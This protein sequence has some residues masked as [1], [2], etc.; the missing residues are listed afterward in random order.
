MSRLLDVLDRAPDHEDEA[1]EAEVLDAVR[2][3]TA[4]DPAA[5][6]EVHAAMTKHRTWALVGWARDAAAV[7]VRRRDREWVVLGLVGLSLFGR[8]FDPRDALLIYPLLGRAAEKLGEDRPA[9]FEEAA[10]LS[11][12]W[13]ERWLA[14]LSTS[15]ASP[16]TMGFEEDN[17]DGRF[18]FRSTRE[19]NFSEADLAD[20][21]NS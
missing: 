8:D 16:E 10:A 21:L 14:G 11:D 7:A 5:R 17:S 19:E 6:A 4:L 13:G 20:L 9:V 18:R 3:L 1:W 12:P 15:S 2:E